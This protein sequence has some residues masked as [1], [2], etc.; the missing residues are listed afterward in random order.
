MQALEAG[1]EDMF[2]EDGESIIYT[3]PK[4]LAKVRQALQDAG[5]SIVE[6]ELTYVP[7]TTIE[8]TDDATAGKLMRLMDALD[9]CDDVVN[10]HV[11]FDID[12]PE[13][14]GTS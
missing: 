7:G 1:A 3:E 6:A 4:E 14:L 10:T 12:V 8:V 13:T 2:E 9:D 11:N 5:L